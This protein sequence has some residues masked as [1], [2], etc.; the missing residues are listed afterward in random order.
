VLNEEMAKDYPTLMV[1]GDGRG[2]RVAIWSLDD[3]G[4]EPEA[5]VNV[6]S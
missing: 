4:I 2:K 6:L 3:D 1:I 5:I